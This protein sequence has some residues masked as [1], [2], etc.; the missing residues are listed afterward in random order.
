MSAEKG[1]IAIQFW[2]GDRA[3]ALRLAKFITDLEPKRREDTDF[4]FVARFDSGHDPGTVKHVSS[5]FNVHTLTTRA[6]GVGHPWGCWCLWFSTIEYL[7]HM[8]R[9]KNFPKYKWVWP[10]EA[11]CVPTSRNWLS[12][13]HAEWDRLN[14]YIVGAETFH[15]HHHAN[16]NLM[17][18]CDPDW[19]KWLVEGITITGVPANDA[20]D[21]YLFPKFVRWGVKFSRRMWN[22]CGA[23]TMGPKIFNYCL[24]EHSFVHGVKDDSV[25][26]QAR[27]HFLGKPAK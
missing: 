20:W 12:E 11:D 1:L 26:K 18:S 4:M 15:Y 10:F 24:R 8:S 3:K 21:I 19:M 27:K 23:S 2:P 13:M 9:K 22:V 7:Y 16:G 17:C 14:G 5:R 25:Y 6:R